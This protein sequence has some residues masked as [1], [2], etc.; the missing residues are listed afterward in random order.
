[1]ESAS[2]KESSWLSVTAEVNSPKFLPEITLVLGPRGALTKWKGEKA[3][4]TSLEEVW[5][6]SQPFKEVQREGPVST[7]NQGKDPL[8]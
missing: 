6:S 5:W 8:V 7:S 3:A 2:L 4:L 1:M